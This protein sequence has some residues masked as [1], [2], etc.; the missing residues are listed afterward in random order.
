[1]SKIA[2][3]GDGERG[4]SLFDSSLNSYFAAL[5]RT[6]LEDYTEA[7]VQQHRVLEWDSWF[8]KFGDADSFDATSCSRPTEAIPEGDSNA[9]AVDVGSPEINIVEP[10]YAFEDKRFVCVD[11]ASIR[12]AEVDGEDGLAVLRLIKELAPH[13]FRLIS[14]SDISL[15]KS[16]LVASTESFS[17]TGSEDS[18]NRVAIIEIVEGSVGVVRGRG[19]GGKELVTC[20]M[21]EGDH[22]VIKLDE[23]S[24]LVFKSGA[25]KLTVTFEIK[26]VEYGQANEAK[27][28]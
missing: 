12:P 8:R 28:T 25:P 6:L 20:G 13:D 23:L 3:F 22:L 4:V 14:Q 1:V 7:V 10:S 15:Q 5:R 18:T 24:T 21:C 16:D 9:R 19:S 2:G 26:L 17:V 11:A 27:V